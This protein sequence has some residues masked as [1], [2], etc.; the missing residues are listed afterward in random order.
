MVIKKTQ[1]FLHKIVTHFTIDFSYE[2]NAIRNE[3]KNVN[4]HTKKST[5]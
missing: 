3:E 4:L 2:L 1:H 5:A